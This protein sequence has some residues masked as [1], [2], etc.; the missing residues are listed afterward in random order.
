[1]FYGT[2][3]VTIL[4]PVY[5]VARFLDVAVESVQKQTY[6]FWE[7]LIIDDG[8]AD[9]TL[10]IALEYEKKESRI[11]VLRHL[12]NLGLVATLNHGLQETRGEFL[13]RLD[14]DDAWCEDTKLAHQV[15]FMETNPLC[16]LV[17]TSARVINEAGQNVGAIHMPVSNADI[18]RQ[19]LFRNTFVHSSVL[20]R[21]ALVRKL[22]GYNENMRH[23]E[24][25]DLWL[26]LGGIAELANLPE[27]STMYRVTNSGVTLTHNREQVLRC[28]K[29]AVLYKRKYPFWLFAWTKWSLQLFLVTLV[30]VRIFRKIKSLLWLN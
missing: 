13:A 29:L 18:R 14:G 15:A 25:Y 16:G 17:G 20:M 28:R 2:P 4:M 26:R 6:V 11:R 1:M 9:S 22:N 7:L 24:D 30:G 21:T 5:N 19:L 10:A 27:L 12:H 3:N 23:V 8:S